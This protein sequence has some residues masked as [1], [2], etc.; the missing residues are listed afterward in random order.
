MLK[1]SAAPSLNQRM[2]VSAIWSGVPSSKWPRPPPSRDRTW[3]T[4]RFSPRPLHEQRVA[5]RGPFD[6]E[7]SGDSETRSPVAD[8]VDPAGVGVPARGLVSHDGVRLPAVPQRLGDRQ[9]L[10]GPGVAVGVAGPVVEPEVGR[11]LSSGRGDDVPAAPAAAHVVDRRQPPGQVVGVVVGRRDGGD[12]PDAA[13]RLRQRRQQRQRL[14]LARRPELA[15]AHRRRAVGQEQ[16]VELRAL[17]QPGQAD[18][19]VQIEV[20]P[21]VAGGQ[22]PR[23]LVVARLHQERVEMQFPSLVSHRLVLHRLV[24]HRPGTFRLS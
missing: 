18:P 19:V 16:R 15:R 24:L 7:R 20:G 12:E 10:V 3:R 23:G 9:E 13:R 22:P 21:R 11:L 4:V 6:V 2:I 14:Q 17:G 1:P 8:L 5:L